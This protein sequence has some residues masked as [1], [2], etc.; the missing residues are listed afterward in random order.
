[1]WPPLLPCSR[2]WHKFFKQP[3]NTFK[4]HTK[5]IYSKLGVKRRNTAVARAQQLGLLS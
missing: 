2:G 3:L 5:N 1:M 4:T